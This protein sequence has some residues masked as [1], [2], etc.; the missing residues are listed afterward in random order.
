MY[1]RTDIYTGDYVDRSVYFHAH[2]R[3]QRASEEANESVE[4]RRPRSVSRAWSCPS[5]RTRRL[6]HYSL[7]VSTAVALDVFT[8]HQRNRSDVQ[9][10]QI[11][12]NL[13]PVDTHLRR[14]AI[15]IADWANYRSVHCGSE[16]TSI[17]TEVNDC[18]RKLHYRSKVF[19]HLRWF[20][21]V[22]EYLITTF[23]NMFAL[24]KILW[25][26]IIIVMTYDYHDYI[27]NEFETNLK[28]HIYR[29]Y[30]IFAI[31][32]ICMLSCSEILSAKCRKNLKLLYLYRIKMYWIA[33]WSLPAFN[34]CWYLVEIQYFP[35]LL[36]STH[37]IIN[38][39]FH[40]HHTCICRAENHR[41]CKSKFWT[42]EFSI[43]T[44]KSIT[45]F[46]LQFTKLP[47]YNLRKYIEF[48]ITQ[49]DI[50]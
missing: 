40:S 36:Y 39:L 47:F 19:E 29:S 16:H 50:L 21:K 32:N 30:K 1:R 4:L 42:F 8:T 13:A 26:F 45:P 10:W 22:F 18:N 31:A 24:S 14:G 20:T 6:V 46:V 3:Q 48:F 37:F 11:I 35:L 9:S 12:R 2:T 28:I 17:S 49:N 23:I 5:R 38:L 7:S 43:S 41:H 44:F 15:V 27:C 25:N 33:S 34:T